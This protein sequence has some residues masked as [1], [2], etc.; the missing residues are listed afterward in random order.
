MINFEKFTEGARES[1]SV[2]QEILRKKKHTE[3]TPLHI[4]RGLLSN[5]ESIV[6]SIIEDLKIGRRNVIDDV[7]RELNNLPYVEHGGGYQVYITYDTEQLLDNADRE[8]ERMKDEYLGSEHLFL[9]LFDLSN[10]VINN[11]FSR[12][13]IT[14]E[15]VYDVL[16]SLRG[17]QRITSENAEKNYN[18]LKKYTRDFTELA[19]QKKL[20]PVIGREEEVERAIEILS[21]RTKNNPVLIGEA[22]VGKTAIV[23][24]LAQKIVDGDV[25]ENLLGRK[26]VGLDMGALVA[27]TQ[28]R[29]EFEQR[30]KLLVDEV[31]KSNGKIILF[32]DEMHNLVGAGRA[33]GSLDA[34]NMLKPALARG[35]MQV[36]GATTIDEYRKYIEKDRALERRFQPI[37]VKEPTVEQTIEIL[38]GLRKKYEEHHKVKITDDALV[39]AAKLSYRYITERKLPDKAID[40]IDEAAARLKLQLFSMPDEIKVLE[41]R[42]KRIQEDGENAVIRKDYEKAAELKKESDKVAEELKK[43]KEEWIKKNS[44]KNEVDGDLVA[45]I[46]SK[47]TGIPVSRM[48]ES[49]KEKLLKME[50]RLHKRVIGQDEA[51]TQI[52][53]AI[54]RSRAGLSD[55]KRPIGS[56]LFVGPTGVGK[57]E[58]AKSLAE[59]LFDSEDALVRIDMS[60]YME[61]FSVSRLV[62]APPGYVGYEEGGQLTEVIRKRPFS[63]V[64]FDEIEKA[65]PDVYNILLQ[66]LDDGR[67][68][69]GQGR[70]VDFRNTIIIMT[71]NIGS[72]IIDFSDD[73]ET[74]KQNIMQKIRN[75][76]KP[77][78]INRLD[79]I[80]VFKNLTKEEIEKIIDIQIENV[81]N[82][83]KEFGIDLEVSKETKEK[84]IEEGYSK[85]FGA[86]PI[87]RAIQVLV[88]NR[89]SEM[90]I[91]G[92]VKKDQKIVI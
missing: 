41:N 62:G 33:E 46:V 21:R 26:I 72:N 81:K 90:I 25:P 34:S 45:S 87:K 63:V 14:K 39:Q 44:L 79:D 22:G 1:I 51:I 37:L 35:E 47:W 71:S 69:S 48:V 28:F 83:A 75:H 73:Y 92:K 16:Q 61:K 31:V 6:P 77:E 68:T 89:L 50:E 53:N 38:K 85:E 57:T 9:G 88:E 17:N 64:L 32:I 18:V 76:F 78:F 52:S 55:P 23:E 27:G 54:R 24:G 49:E 7:D 91:S 82:R 40:L 11:I 67:L 74:I 2:A 8:R 29:G 36:I 3:L 30:L 86:R 4:L 5:E 42:L 58:V 65:H 80:I 84:I 43:K 20:D 15:K 12:Y 19:K 13:N 66:V 10:R 59:F 56:F 70:T 60:E